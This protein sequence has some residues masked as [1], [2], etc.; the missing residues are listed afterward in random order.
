M[1]TLMKIH[2]ENG[3]RH[4]VLPDDDSVTMET[5]FASGWNPTKGHDEQLDLY[6][7]SKEEFGNIRGKL[8]KVWAANKKD[9][10]DKK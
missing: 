1:T 2:D 4:Y 7:V 5:L 6:Q 9:K 8:R 3:T 10:E